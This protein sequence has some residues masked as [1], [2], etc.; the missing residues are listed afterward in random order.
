MK[1]LIYLI[2]LF[3]AC[4][5]NDPSNYRFLSGETFVSLLFICAIMALVIFAPKLARNK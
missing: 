1:K 4:D 2:P 3:I 5:P